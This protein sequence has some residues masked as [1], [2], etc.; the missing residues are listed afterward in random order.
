MAAAEPRPRVPCLA[1]RQ[2][3]DGWG[4]ICLRREGHTGPHRWCR[5][6]EASVRLTPAGRAALYRSLQAELE[7][8][9]P[10]AT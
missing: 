8:E 6:D 5:D 10:R 2:E 9:V 4:S 3:G 1:D 7:V